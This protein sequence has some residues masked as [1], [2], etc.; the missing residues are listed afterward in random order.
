MKKIIGILCVP[1]VAIAMVININSAN[2]ITNP[3]TNLDLANLMLVAHAENE[4]DCDNDPNDT[5]WNPETGISYSN[6]D[7]SSFWDTCGD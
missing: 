2:N 1:L 7:P 4:T 6:C 3:S 5:C